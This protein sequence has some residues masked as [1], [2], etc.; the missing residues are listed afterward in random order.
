[1]TNDKMQLINIGFTTDIYELYL[2]WL[3]GHRYSKFV[4]RALKEQ[5][6]LRANVTASRVSGDEKRTCKWSLM[7]FPSQIYDKM[8]PG[9]AGSEMWNPNTPISEDC[10]Y[11]NV[12]VPRTHPQVLML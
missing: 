7:F 8:F 11:L 3:L 12:A 4:L 5:R 9:F 2:P 1:M 6:S 10:L